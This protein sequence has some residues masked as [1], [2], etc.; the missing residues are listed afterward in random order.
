MMSLILERLET[1]GKESWCV[2]E[3]KGEKNG[4]RNCGRVDLEGRQQ[5]ESK[6]IK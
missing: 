5:L 1:P 2:G 4:M 3:S 6:S